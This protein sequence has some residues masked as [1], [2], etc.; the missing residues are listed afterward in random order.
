M[1]KVTIPTKIRNN[2]FFDYTY[3]TVQEVN[4]DYNSEDKSDNEFE[5][6]DKKIEIEVIPYIPLN[7]EATIIN[8]YVGLYFNILNTEEPYQYLKDGNFD[9]HRAEIALIQRIMK[10]LTNMDT[11]ETDADTMVDVFYKA[12]C[13][14]ENYSAFRKRLNATIEAIKD[15]KSIGIVLDG[16]I[17]RVQ[18]ILQ[19]FSNIDPEKLKEVADSVIQK[20]ENSSVAPIFQEA[21]QS[22]KPTSNKT[23][24]KVKEIKE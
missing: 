20:M 17:T 12:V 10:E 18:D 24:R 15:S 21:A 23:K 6:V 2:V 3:A 14:I 9:A 22:V 1:E 11:I 4:P 8:D 16:L 19:S 13:Y 7:I 5:W